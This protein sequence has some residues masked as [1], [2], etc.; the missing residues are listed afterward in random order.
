MA[1]PD[2]NTDYNAA[3]K[4]AAAAPTQQSG[5]PD[6]NTD[7]NAAVTAGQNPQMA[8]TGSPQRLDNPN[9][10]FGGPR[11]AA[12]IA[13]YLAG[14]ENKFLN[15]PQNL[16]QGKFS[17]LN[18]QAALTGVGA[19]NTN[20]AT[21]LNNVFSPMHQYWQKIMAKDPT[22]ATLGGLSAD[23]VGMAPSMGAGVRAYQ[24]IADAAKAMAPMGAANAATGY[25]QSDPN[26]TQGEKLANAAIAGTGSMA[27]V[28]IVDKAADL[29]RGA[30]YMFR[31]PDELAQTALQNATK[32]TGNID[33][34]TPQIALNHVQKVTQ[35]AKQEAERLYAERDSAAHGLMVPRDNLLSHALTLNSDVQKGATPEMQQALATTKSVLGNG[36]ALSFKDAQ[37]LLS[38]VRESA[39][40][41]GD[42]GNFA[43]QNQYKQIG[44]ALETDVQGAIHK[45]PDAM[46][47]QSYHDAAQT[48]YKSVYGPLRSANA[49]GILQDN[50]LN[51]KFANAVKPLMNAPD[52]LNAL[53]EDGTRTLAL[54]HLNAIKQGSVNG[55]TNQL[56]VRAYTDGLGKA[57]KDNPTIFNKVVPQMGALSDALGA[58]KQIGA[59]TQGLSQHS[60]G[61]KIMLGA[62]MA[63]GAAGGY[64]GY[65]S[66]GA[67][68]GLLGT[69]A[70]YMIP[71]GKFLFAAGKLLQNPE[72]RALLKRSADLPP[73]VAPAIKQYY[74]KQILSK[75]TRI[76]ATV[77]GPRLFGSNGDDTSV[78]PPV[79]SQ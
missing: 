12:S 37:Q 56:N 43:L 24:G 32:A 74:N 9:L 65:K 47:I 38:R 35:D 71:K 29:L 34:V 18:A 36:D 55:L 46:W 48:Y 58:A 40:T 63:G 64:Q 51:S 17:Q 77:G 5:D 67:E 8:Q 1:S 19:Q 21:Q 30:K 7:Y 23:V 54:A 52:V 4:A 75:F 45:S 27:G 26:A 69:A 44:D 57:L 28:G 11:T 25:L 50:L 62:Q 79:S 22:A 14:A 49:Q 76:A 70:G 41:A 15:L 59:V 66:G 13:P 3:V 42:G 16:L 6:F 53:G 2:F 20:A 60:L 39:F 72:T 78:Q 61:Q 31:S 10:P 73:T 68:G 33:D